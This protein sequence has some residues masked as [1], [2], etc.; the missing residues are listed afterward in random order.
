MADTISY[1]EYVDNSRDD[2]IWRPI[3]GDEVH[4]FNDLT[5]NVRNAFNSGTKK[6]KGD[7]LENLM[8]FV[9]RRFKHIRVYHDEKR[10]DNQ[11]DHIVEFIDGA[12]PTFIHQYIGLTLIGESKNL[13]KSIGVREVADLHELLRSKESK[14]GIFSSY[15]PF[16]K[17][18]SIWNYA[19]GKRRKLALT[20]SLLDNRKII[21]FTIDEIES[22]VENNFYTMLKQK[23]YNLVNE[24]KDDYVDYEN[25]IIPYQARL[26]QS[27]KQLYENQVIDEDS[28][29]LGV[30][31]IETQ[32][33]PIENDY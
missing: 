7:S 26:Y 24:L 8:S 4:V 5:S 30:K 18:N 25:Q 21:G 10:G 13:K 9:Y 1:N 22:L 27:L 28:F 14:L 11:I 6:E 16:S 2:N 17:G 19:E 15:H 32:F 3:K 12:T 29:S 31:K 23:Y 33:G 20:Y